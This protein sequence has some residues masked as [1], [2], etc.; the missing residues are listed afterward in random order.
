MKTLTKVA[1]CLAI[2]GCPLAMSAAEVVDSVATAGNVIQQISVSPDSV[3][4]AGNV[5]PDTNRYVTFRGDTIPIILKDRTI[6]RYDRKLYNYLF[7]P[8]G[9]WSFGLTASYGEINTKDIELMSLL[10]D[11]SLGGHQY[12]IRPSVQYFIKNNLAVGLRLAYTKGHA[13]VDSFGV[14]V[15]DDMSFNLKDVSYDSESYTAAATLRKYFGIGP[16]G[17][18]AIFNEIEL[19]FSSGNSDFT[20]PFAGE[21]KTTHATNMTAA[22][23][24]SPGVSVLVMKNVGFNVS[25]GVFGFKLRSEKQFVNDEPIGSR[26]TSGANFRFNIF[27]INFGLVVNI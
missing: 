18:F 2:T 11:V 15:G 24:F 5:I 9:I 20:R 17:R 3:P 8:K 27:N 26:F 13:G 1:L 7:L 12:S 22:L 23:N 19:A 21:L 25:F 10:T 16:S 6:G 14:D 4:E